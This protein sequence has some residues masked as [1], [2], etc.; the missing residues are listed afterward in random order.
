MNEQLNLLDIT[1]DPTL[2]ENWSQR[3]ERPGQP[4]K[5]E[6][7]ATPSPVEV[8]R[9]VPRVKLPYFVV[10]ERVKTTVGEGIV[11]RVDSY[12]WVSYPHRP[13]EPHDRNYVKKICYQTPVVMVCPYSD[14]VAMVRVHSAYSVRFHA[15]VG[16]Q[17]LNGAKQFVEFLQQRGENGTLQR[18]P[19]YLSFP[20]EVWA[21]GLS[22]ER[23]NILVERSLKAQQTNLFG[24]CAP[25]CDC[26]T[27]L[28]DLGF[29]P[30]PVEEGERLETTAVYRGWA[31]SLEIPNGGIIAVDI[32]HLESGERYT[33]CT[34]EEYDYF[35]DEGIVAMAREAI[36]AVGG[37]Q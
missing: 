12:V 6:P 20:F 5:T 35:D 4:Q 15:A 36:D 28:A 2:A 33:R 16:F 13:D 19:K 7:P 25:I 11:S 22:E 14:R 29:I 24:G 32:L 34:E 1:P 21:W 31:I 37:M 9:Y 26:K 17:T 18:Q 30:W 23:F 8:Y 10:G 3:F 27:L